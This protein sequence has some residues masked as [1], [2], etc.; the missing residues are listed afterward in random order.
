VKPELK[1]LWENRHFVAVNK[2][3]GLL[4][5]PATNSREVS[6]LKLLSG[7]YPRQKHIPVHRLDRDTSGVMLIARDADAHREANR[8]FEKH[9][10]KKE[11][12]AMAKGNPRLPAFKL[13]SPI[14][15]KKALSQVQIIE[16]FGNGKGGAFL[17]RVRIATGRRHQI[18]IHLGKEGYP[19]L[20]DTKYGG[21]KAYGGAEFARFA[22]HAE[23]LT[24]PPEAAAFGVKKNEMEI[25]A[26]EPGDFSEWVAWLRGLG[27]HPEIGN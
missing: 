27:D 25:V 21:V 9:L 15:G 24:L 6:V 5:V 8:W 26:P 19:I 20:G 22:L 11:Y 16:R 4:S 1:I 14:E 2:P 17:A 18:R 12:L 7:L 13:A 23:R 3:A 10:I